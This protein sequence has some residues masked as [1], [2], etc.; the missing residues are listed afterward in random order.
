M[1]KTIKILNGME[2][3]R[4]GEERRRERKEE[5][6]RERLGDIRKKTSRSQTKTSTFP[7]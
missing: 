6:G 4:R 5:R 3:K 7:W 1:Y 2:R